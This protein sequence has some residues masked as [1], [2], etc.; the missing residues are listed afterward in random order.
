M[1][2]IVGWAATCMA[3]RRM[4]RM[5]SAARSPREPQERLLNAIL[6]RGRDTAFGQA[7]H[8]AHVK[9]IR[10]L[11]SFVPLQN[12]E[13][14][15]EWWDRARHGEASVTWP[16]LIRDWAIS[17]G[18]TSG[19]KY[20]PVSKET[21]RSNKQGGFDALVPHLVEQ[22]GTLFGGKMLFLGGSTTM[23]EVN[24]M[25]IGDNTGIMARN[26]P[27]PISRWHA[28]SKDIQ[29]MGNWEEKVQLAA[30]Q[31]W[32]RDLRLLSGVPSWI[33]L[34]GEHVLAAAARAGRQVET[35]AELWPKLE[36]F[37]HGGVA[38]GPYRERTEQL[39][40]KAIRYTDTYS[41]SEG[42]M[43]AVQD[44]LEDSA[45]LP[46]LDRGAVYEFVPAEELHKDAPTR[47]AID[48]VELDVDYAV[49]L[50]TNSG[51]YSYLV[52]DLVRFVTRDPLR[53]VFAGRIAHTLNIVG[54]H[55]CGGEVDRAILAASQAS[56]AQV[57][58]F[59]VAARYPDASDPM[60][61]HVYLVEFERSPNDMELF[62]RALD[63]SI[64]SGNEDY[65]T[66]RRYGMHLPAIEPLPTG[67]F[68]EW[69]RQNGKIGGQ[70]KI[71]RVLSESIASEIRI[72]ATPGRDEATKAN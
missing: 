49:A 35:L 54:E 70:H 64:Q 31:L 47:L 14:M 40:G 39:I 44:R 21:I 7:H 19:E 28:P 25:R 13:S 1:N 26:V 72:L 50:T 57:A 10:D 45:M 55:V 41:A 52:G 27:W 11:A 46:L 61:Q 12:Y 66:H 56:G 59:G 38:F 6:E 5:L 3:R 67:T 48:Q 34:F 16:G 20:L 24:G 65:A 33:V 9:D 62:V 18:T 60:A 63:E 58:E 71:P 69:M 51:I 29:A 36:L 30:E 22:G 42:G 15:R 2:S 68:M 17:S 53:L 23:R 37:V 43:L 4:K 32:N 8:L